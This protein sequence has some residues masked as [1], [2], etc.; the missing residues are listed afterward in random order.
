MRFTYWTSS[1]Q[2]IALPEES[3]NIT[4]A[5]DTLAEPV[6]DETAIVDVAGWAFI[7]AYSTEN[8]RIYLVLESSSSVYVFDT[9]VRMRPD[10]TQ[11]FQELGLNLDSSGFTAKIRKEAIED[12]LYRIGIYIKGNNVDSL[13]FTG[14][15]LGKSGDVIDTSPLSP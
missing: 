12:G 15:S 6:E 14:R 10:V 2:R 4:F 3:G 9:L 8:S 11:A 13:R 1:L 7:Q 5:I